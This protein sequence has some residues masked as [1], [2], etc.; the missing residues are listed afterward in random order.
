MRFSLIILLLA[1]G[2]SIS[3]QFNVAV[4]YSL[5]YT[6]AEDINNLVFDFNES[7]RNDTYF[8]DQMP[9]LHVL[10]GVN[11]GFRWKYD[12]ISFELAWELMNRTR[13]AL[14]ENSQDQLFQKTIFF[15]INS[16]TAGVESNFGNLGLG[17][18][19]GF[20][21]L[22]IKE[23]IAA[24]NKKRSFLEER[25]YFLKPSLSIN[26][27]GNESL[28]LSIKPYIQ[29]PFSTFGLDPLS[30][31]FGLGDTGDSESL[32]IGGVSFIFYNGA[33]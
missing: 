25:Q 13:E 21:N 4:G 2:Q 8:G 14:G 1:L 20:R 3:A 11:I 23:E 5:G 6:Q 16:Y 12:F 9:E 22:A 26:L 17:L 28:G 19:V 30:Q 29:I 7:F 24:T 10:H 32:L 18:A 31:E 27:I 33:Q 15:N